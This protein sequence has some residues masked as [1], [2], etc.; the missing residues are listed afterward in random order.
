MARRCPLQSP[1][2]SLNNGGPA[3][4]GAYLSGSTDSGDGEQLAGSS[5]LGFV[6]GREDWGPK[7]REGSEW[8]EASQAIPS[9]MRV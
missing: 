7:D 3:G 9:P 6:R 1:H 8:A 5:L 4:L 2:R